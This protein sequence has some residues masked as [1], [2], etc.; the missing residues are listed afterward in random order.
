MY[1]LS[2]SLYTP[3]HVKRILNS[4]FAYA[5]LEMHSRHAVL[6]YDWCCFVG[7]D[8][9]FNAKFFEYLSY[10]FKVEYDLVSN[11]DKIQSILLGKIY[12]TI[13]IYMKNKPSP[14]VDKVIYKGHHLWNKSKFNN[15]LLYN[16]IVVWY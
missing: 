11:P 12:R 7:A 2:F 4:G 13:R 6:M 15:D 1:P 14:I 10:E 8:H 9:K 5:T 16:Q 3:R